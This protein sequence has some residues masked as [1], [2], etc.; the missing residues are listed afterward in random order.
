M[1]QARR[2][3]SVASPLA[4]SSQ[5]GGPRPGSGRGAST[6]VLTFLV[7]L[8]FVAV[9]GG[10]LGYMFLTAPKTPAS[11]PGGLKATNSKG[12]GAHVGNGSPSA[13]TPTAPVDDAVTSTTPSPSLHRWAH[14]RTVYPYEDMDDM[15][16]QLIPKKHWKVVGSRNQGGG[17]GGGMVAANATHASKGAPPAMPVAQSALLEATGCNVQYVPFRPGDDARCIDY[18]TNTSNWAEL[19]PLPMRFDAR[20]I[21]FQVRFLQKDLHCVLKVPQRLFPNEAFAEV[22]AYHADRVLAVNRIPPTGW[23]CIP[24][25]LILEARDRYGATL[26]TEQE[27]LKDSKVTNYNDW[28][29]KDLL[30]YARGQGLVDRTGDGG[31]CI[32]ASMQLHVADAHHML[33]SPLRIPYKAHDA[34]WHQYFDLRNYT[35]AEPQEGAVLPPD[36]TVDDDD[37]DDDVVVP[38]PPKLGN[39]SSARAARVPPI[40]RVPFRASLVHIAELNAF[41]YIIGNDDR[42]PNK[43]NFVV[44]KCTRYCD[45]DEGKDFGASAEHEGPP[46]FVHLD[47]GMAFYGSVHRNPIKKG[48][49]NGSFCV[50][51][52][53]MLNRLERLAQDDG[54]G[55][56]ERAA[57]VTQMWERMPRALRRFLPRSELA[58][59]GRRITKLLRLAEDC[60][61]RPFS[62]YVVAP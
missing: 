15:I 59:C 25:K 6:T 53:P 56:D 45:E 46:T 18:L 32:G 39:R 13:A 22:A 2:A 50:F 51:R 19:V 21:K 41:D 5:T 49:V 54:A 10:L 23:V 55:D 3:V 36:P 43:N 58:V 16:R 14:D 48:F 57:F 52:A 60:V 34:S 8:L 26:E 37:D 47:Q 11:R 42:S 12:K 1:S 35:S 33:D 17:A 29:K 38:K 9:N 30:D 7:L 40:A 31:P 61:G 20:T 44:G 24:E 4:H 28:L 62:K 27:F